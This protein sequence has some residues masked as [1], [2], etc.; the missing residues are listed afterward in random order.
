MPIFSPA[1]LAFVH[2]ARV[3]R[4]A[5]ASMAGE[6][7]LIPVCFVY[8]GAA[9]YTAVDAKPKRVVP[10]RLRRIQNIRGNP[11]AALLLDRYEEDWSRLRYVLVRGRAELLE[12]GSGDARAAA[13]LL[14]EKYP[15]YRAM[16]GF[17]EAP[18][19]RLVPERVV[20]WSAQQG[21]E[22]GPGHSAG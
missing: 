18:I 5:T 13:A 8:D 2:E 9:F 1:D 22:A 10:S 21:G 14:R 12:A 20:R 3:G 19:I 16:P 11:R 7:H 17:G 6:P 15:Q 4:L